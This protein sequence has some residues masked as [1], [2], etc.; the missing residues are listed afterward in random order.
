MMLVL[1]SVCANRTCASV[2][3][4][5]AWSAINKNWVN[6]SGGKSAVRVVQT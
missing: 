2:G 5:Q 1:A 4:E 6:F 3:A